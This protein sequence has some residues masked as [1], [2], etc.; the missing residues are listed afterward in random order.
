MFIR[1]STASTL[2]VHSMIRSR[3]TLNKIR[4]TG[5]SMYHFWIVTSLTFHFQCAVISPFQSINT[6]H[7]CTVFLDAGSVVTDVTA[8]AV[9]ADVDPTAVAVVSD[10]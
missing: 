8:D 4:I 10:V 1:T 3:D 9:V 6:D 5:I 7:S 2:A